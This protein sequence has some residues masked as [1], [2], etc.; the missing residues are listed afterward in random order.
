LWPAITNT[1]AFIIMVTLALYYNGHSRKSYL[2][3][4]RIFRDYL[5]LLAGTLVSAT[6]GMGASASFP[7]ASIAGA[8]GSLNPAAMLSYTGA[9]GSAGQMD[10][11]V[12]SGGSGGSSV[13]GGGAAGAWTCST[14]SAGQK[15][16]GGGSGGGGNGAV[17]CG[18][19]GVVAFAG[20]VGASG[21]V[22]VTEYSA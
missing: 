7:G 10:S 6:G 2:K 16:G 14:G 9:G 21:V 4:L 11:Q 22:V 5:A 1:L 8:G 19:S 15:W 18:L 3:Q 12:A 13:F 17:P 20:G